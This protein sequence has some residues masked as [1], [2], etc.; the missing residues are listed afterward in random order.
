MKKAY[1]LLL[2]LFFAL[3]WLQGCGTTYNHTSSY[4]TQSA[5]SETSESDWIHWSDDEGR[6]TKVLPY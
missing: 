1:I 3:L 4:Q 6:H 5:N 2:F